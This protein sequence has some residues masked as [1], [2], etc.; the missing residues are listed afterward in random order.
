MPE[1]RGLDRAAAERV[2]RRAIELQGAAEAGGDAFDEARLVAIAA[3]LGIERAHVERAVAEE[4]AG[5]SPTLPAGA[6]S[7]LAGPALADAR[8][9][10]RL[11]AT[12]VEA[13]LHER[14]ERTEG[15]RLVRR[16]GGTAVYER[17]TDAAARAIGGLGSLA[18]HD[19][20]L[21]GARRVCAVVVRADA[22]MAAV[23][24][25]AEPATSRGATARTAGLFAGGGVAL[26]AA[27]ALAAEPAFLA[28]AP[29]GVVAA[30]AVLAARR[31]TVRRLGDGLDDTLAAVESGGRAPSPLDALRGGIGRLAGR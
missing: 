17:R 25:T 18:G 30:A 9:V 1:R 6:G 26:A 29:A 7:W 22:G 24:V 3:E 23:R 20:R 16:A 12:A 21:R 15:L 11:D 19:R 13:A 14:L 4:W 27:G 8:G 2:L 31:R 5:C 28:A 10:L